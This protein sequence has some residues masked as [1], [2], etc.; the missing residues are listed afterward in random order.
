MGKILIDT[1]IW[2]FL[3][4]E[5]WKLSENLLEEFFLND[6]FLSGFSLWEVSMLEARGRIKFK[7][8]IREWISRNLKRNNISIIYPQKEIFLLSNELNIDNSDPADRIIIATG[9]EHNLKL[10]THDKKIINSNLIEI[11]N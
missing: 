8:P 10:A 6:L 1:H 4:K 7:E 2:I 3:V 11:V 9:L 5:R